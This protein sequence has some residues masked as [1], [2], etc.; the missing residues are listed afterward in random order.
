MQPL[1]QITGVDH[2]ALTVRDLAASVTFYHEILGLELLNS[3]EYTAGTRS[4]LSVRVGN[5][6]IDL[7]PAKPDQLAASEGATLNHFC[8]YLETE[9]NWEQ[10]TTHLRECGLEIISESKHNWGSFG[11]GDSVYV[12]DPDGNTVELKKY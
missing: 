8:L 10:F 12:K 9:A 3:E 1:F 7:F 4:F 2:V 5:S 6:L 11:Y